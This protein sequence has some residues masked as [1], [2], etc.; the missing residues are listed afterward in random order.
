MRYIKANR[1]GGHQSSIDRIVM[2]STVTPCAPGWAVKVAKMFHR[3]S[4][5]ASAHYVVD[6]DRVVRCLPDHTVAYHAPPNLHSLGVEQCDWSK[7]K[8]SRWRNAAHRAMLKRSA[9]L[10]ARLCDKYD[11]PKRH[12]GP[13][14]LRRGERGICAHYDVT[15]AWHQ[16]THTDPDDFPWGTFLQLVRGGAEEE[17]VS[18]RW[19]SAR[20][21]NIA[22]GKHK[23]W[24]TVEFYDRRKKKS[25]PAFLGGKQHIKDAKLQLQVEGVENKPY[26]VRVIEVEKKHGHWRKTQTIGRAD[27][28]GG[29]GIDEQ[30]MTFAPEKTAKGCHVW[31]QLHAPAGAVLKWACVKTDC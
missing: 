30:T 8:A 11:I 27:Y 25:H 1:H 9:R 12:V 6:C 14:Q 13:A 21:Q 7:G 26:K 22:Q 24:R 29:P 16:T 10:V 17:H 19:R 15:H 23:S 2:H 4:K 3:W 31:A 28:T 20:R 18:Y 5:P